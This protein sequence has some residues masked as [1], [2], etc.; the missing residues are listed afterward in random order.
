[1]N[2]RRTVD[3]RKIDD[4]QTALM[5]NQGFPVN[6]SHVA[7]AFCRAW[8]SETGVPDYDYLSQLYAP[9]D[10]VII[11]DALP[12]LEGFRGFQQVR[13]DLYPELANIHVERTGDVAV[14]ELAHGVVVVTSYPLRL[15]YT[16]TDGRAVTLDARM[17]EVWERRGERYLIVHE[18]PSTVYT[19][20]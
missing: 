18:H 8:S 7:D 4:M 5:P 19:I 15:A 6:W 17:S 9:D 16:F 13:S 11:Y 20:S 14:R 3:E 10:D 1:M 2:E 12:P